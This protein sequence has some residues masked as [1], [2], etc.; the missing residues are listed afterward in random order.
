[1][2]NFDLQ[3][4]LNNI[5]ISMIGLDLSQKPLLTGCVKDRILK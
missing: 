4:A 1:M 3:K 2:N 5:N